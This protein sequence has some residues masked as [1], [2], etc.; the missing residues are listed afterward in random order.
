MLI[1]GGCGWSAVAL[2]S[3][4]LLCEPRGGSHWPSS[5]TPGEST[6]PASLVPPSLGLLGG[7]LGS[8]ENGLL[9]V[10][11]TLIVDTD[12]IRGSG[13]SSVILVGL[14]AASEAARGWRASRSALPLNW[15]VSAA[16]RW[17]R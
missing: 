8:W 1:R 15:V 12:V 16:G 7:D 6:F 2:L 11:I 14:P 13:S 10:A 9:G 17:G 5:D 4:C 3:R